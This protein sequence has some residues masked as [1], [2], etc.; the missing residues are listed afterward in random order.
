[1]NKKEYRQALEGLINESV[2]GLSLDEKLAVVQQSVAETQ[3]EIGFDQGNKAQPW[4]DEELRLVLRLAPTR[5]NCVLLARAFRRGIGSIDLIYR[6]A[7]SS[8]SEVR[9]KRPDDKF[10]SQVKRV[11]RENGWCV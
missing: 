11:A 2:D 5:E 4:T 6:W 1:M 9:Q 7:M 10:I 8:D 3:S